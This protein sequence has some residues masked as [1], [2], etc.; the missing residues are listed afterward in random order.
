MKENAVVL[1]IVQL[2]ASGIYLREPEL[3]SDQC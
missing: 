2:I 1:Y 3:I